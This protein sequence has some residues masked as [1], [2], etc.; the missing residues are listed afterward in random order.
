MSLAAKGQ[1][2]KL[3]N[4]AGALQDLSAFILDIQITEAVGM[5]RSET[6][7]DTGE[8]NTPT[9]TGG[10]IQVTFE[11][12]TTMLT[13]LHNIKG[14]ANTQTFEYGEDGSTSGKPKTSGEC[15]LATYQRGGAVAGLVTGQ[16]AF[17]IDGA[18]AHGTFA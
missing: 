7:G 3:D 8:E 11:Y 1:A 9:L 4:S 15:R 16:A 14:H 12:N 2:F 17:N 10:Q 18:V 13:H 5:E 6:M